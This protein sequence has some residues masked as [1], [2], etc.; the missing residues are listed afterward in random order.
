MYAILELSRRVA[1][2]WT[3]GLLLALPGCA[4]PPNVRLAQLEQSVIPRELDKATL[5]AYVVEPPDILLI[6]T[7][8]T[9]RTAESRLLPGD[10]LQV[11]LKNGLPID[12][13]VDPETNPLQF[14]AEL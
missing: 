7:V 4:T 12:V 5:P 1:K 9:L 13:G 6:Q 11:R 2:W 3:L 10:R 14:N 8:N